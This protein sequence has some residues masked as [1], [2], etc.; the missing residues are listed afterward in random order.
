MRFGS[1]VRPSAG[2]YCCVIVGARNLFGACGHVHAWR[3]R[4]P[5]RTD[6]AARPHLRL[7]DSRRMAEHLQLVRG[8]ESRD[9]AAD[10]E[11]LL[12]GLRVNRSTCGRG[13]ATAVVIAA[14]KSRG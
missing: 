13:A 2:T 6:A 8:A 5:Q 3:E 7:D 1:S 11:H 14:K 4:L 10:H 9:P 12:G